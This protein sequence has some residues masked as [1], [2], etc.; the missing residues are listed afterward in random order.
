MNNKIIAIAVVAVLVV[1]GAVAVI[2]LSD[3]EGSYAIESELPIYGNANNDHTLDGSDIDLIENIIKGDASLSDHPLADANQDGKITQADADVVQN[4]LDNKKTTVYIQ[5]QIGETVKIQYPLTNIVTIN[6]DLTTFVSCLG[7]I[8]N[9][10]GYISGSYPVM[11]SGL[12]NGGAE[13]IGSGR[14]LNDAAWK[15]LMDLDSKLNPEGGVGAIIVDR[16][17][18]L[19]D[20]ADDVETAQIPVIAI[21]VTDPELSIQGALL[22]GYLMSPDNHEQIMSY[23][24][25][26][27]KMMN[28]LND[29]LEKLS[30][31]ERK[32]FLALN[33]TYYIAQDM[34]QYNLIG[35]AAGGKSMTM[36]TGSSSDKLESVE[37]IK[38]YDNKVDFLLN[39]STMDCAVENI[40]EKYE[41]KNMMYLEK[42]TAYDNH[43]FINCS[44]PITCRVMYSAAIMYPDIISMD[45]AD[46]FLQSMVD[47]YLTFLHDT[48]EDGKMDITKDMTT[49][50]SYQDYLD[51]KKAA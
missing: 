44:M 21:R 46:Q 32:G 26:C 42:S 13:K 47:K 7:I 6:S 40:I 35:K 38:I 37:A 45:E 19:L 10:A 34:S 17:E 2:S 25:D 5:D 28:K 39:Y 43:Y 30:D 20:Y 12:D 33:M 3:D 48:Q 22:L 50:I 9:V 36:T 31:S 14:Q 11:Q 41:G 16:A 49:V 51:A 29:G 4:I 24:A 1:A 8:D 18:A 23:V 27:E 15:G